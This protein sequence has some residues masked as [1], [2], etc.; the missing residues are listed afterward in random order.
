M[1]LTHASGTIYLQEVDRFNDLNEL[2]HN[3]GYKGVYKVCLRYS[4]LI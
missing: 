2:F 1:I 3:Y 4:V